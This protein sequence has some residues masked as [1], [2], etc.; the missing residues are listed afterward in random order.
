MIHIHENMAAQVNPSLS[1]APLYIA[2][3]LPEDVPP[4]TASSHPGH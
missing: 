4:R 2:A 3:E 1:L